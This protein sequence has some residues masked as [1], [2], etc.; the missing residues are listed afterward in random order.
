VAAI[1]IVS[2]SAPQLNVTTPPLATAA[3]TAAEVQLAG[4]PL[5]MTVVGA[6]TLLNWPPAGTEHEPA[7]LPAMGPVAGLGDGAGEGDGEG[8]GPGA[9]GVAG[10]LDGGCD[11]AGVVPPPATGAMA[12][13]ALAS[14]PPPPPQAIRLAL[15]A[16]IRNSARS[17]IGVREMEELQVEGIKPA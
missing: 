2:G 8:A 3:T 17:R 10:G 6:A 16:H 12:L 13:S 7:G 15:A 5:P 4:V 11:G 1:V 9:G 14:L